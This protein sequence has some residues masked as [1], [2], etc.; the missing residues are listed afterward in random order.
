M[1]AE[2][3]DALREEFFWRKHICVGMAPWE[4]CLACEDELRYWETFGPDAPDEDERLLD[5]REVIDE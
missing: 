2:E 5:E 4:T 1:D 3:I